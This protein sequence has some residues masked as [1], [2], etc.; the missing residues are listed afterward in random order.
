M[1]ERPK[2]KRKQSGRGNDE[3]AARDRGLGPPGSG[4]DSQPTEKELRWCAWGFL[5]ACTQYSN[6]MPPP[7][8]EYM[9]A[10][11]EMHG[12]KRPVMDDTMTKEDW[13]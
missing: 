11:A 8:E 7:T 13:K 9:Q 12:L 6:G 2:P 10:L 3:R 4:N 1:N 5:M